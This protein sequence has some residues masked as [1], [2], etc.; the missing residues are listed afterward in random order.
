MGKSITDR[1]KALANK[2]KTLINEMRLEPFNKAN[3][4]AML[5]TLYPPATASPPTRQLTSTILA[6]QRNAFFRYITGVEKNGKSILKNLEHQGKRPEDAN[7][8]PVV[9]EIVDKYLRTANGIVEECQEITGPNSL[10]PSSSEYHRAERRSDSGISFATLDRPST[11]SSNNSRNNSIPSNSSRTNSI[12]PLPACPAAELPPVP[13]SSPKKR[14]TT[15]E[16]IAREIRNLRTRNDVRELDRRPL[17]ESSRAPDVSK[18]KSLKKMKSTS[19]IGAAAARNKHARSGSGDCST[20][21]YDIDD[22][23]RERLIMEAKREKENREPL[24]KSRMLGRDYE[25]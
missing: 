1:F 8:W 25:V 13:P 18:S 10:D 9:R 15:L 4:L 5:N 20:S 3:C 14:G 6:S 7:G 22:L 16:K 19:S 11:S 12:K 23:K 2:Q 17:N 21:S 24:T